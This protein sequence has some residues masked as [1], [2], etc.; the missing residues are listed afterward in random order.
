MMIDSNPAA[1]ASRVSTTEN[2]RAGGDFTINVAK[3][4]GGAGDLATA[5]AAFRA[6]ASKTPRERCRDQ[7]MKEWKITQEY[8]DSLPPKEAMALNQ[9]IEEEVSRRMQVAPP[10][11]GKASDQTDE[12]S[13]VGPSAPPSPESA[14]STLE[15]LTARGAVVDGSGPTAS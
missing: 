10:S 13:D 9:R 8:V 1:A 4:V 6:E 7:V 5:L 12:P 14:T 3:Q 15:Q 2:R 11:S